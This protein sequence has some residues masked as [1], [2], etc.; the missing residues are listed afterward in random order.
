MID[1]PSWKSRGGYSLLTKA[2]NSVR[3]KWYSRTELTEISRPIV[4]C[5]NGKEGG[6]V[7]SDELMTDRAQ[8]KFVLVNYTASK[9]TGGKKANTR[10][11]D[12]SSFHD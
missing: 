6:E 5:R 11:V 4:K 7:K 3:E 9:Q 12:V 2:G 10:K 1:K 8:Q